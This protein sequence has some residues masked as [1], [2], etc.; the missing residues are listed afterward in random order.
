VSVALDE[1][2][3]AAV[4]AG[5][6]EVRVEVGSVL[7]DAAL[8]VP[9]G[10]ASP[11]GDIGSVV[12]EGGIIESHVMAAGLDLGA[13]IVRPTA[14]RM[15]VRYAIGLA[16]VADYPEAA[17]RPRATRYTEAAAALA[18]AAC[19]IAE[20]AGGGRAAIQALADE[21]QA[22]F[23]YGHPDE[24]FNDGLDQVPYLSCGLAEGSCVDINTYFVASLRAAGFDAAYLYGYFFP[25]ERGGQT[26]D[27]HCWVVTRH[28]G[29]TLEWDIAHHM[30]AGLGAVRP[31]RNPRPGWRIALGHSMGHRYRLPGGAT[32]D[33][34][35]LAE[36]LW[37]RDD[38]AILPVA[39]VRIMMR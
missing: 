27:M 36:P 23:T 10:I 19:D 20:R 39:P 38:G 2:P 15:V 33:L 24:R 3:G 25:V 26:N 22:R 8:V 18:A 5:T 12:V 17:F 16:C 4:I 7:A 32:L 11:L 28:A 29:E 9:A 37:R 34:K 1:R 14:E 21:A 13:L 6:D 31:A 30:K 35:L